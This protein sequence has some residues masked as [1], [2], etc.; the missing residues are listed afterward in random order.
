MG[1]FNRLSDAVAALTQKLVILLISVTML[2]LVFQVFCRYIL[3]RAPSWTDELALFCFSWMVFLAGS[4]GVKEGFHVSLDLLKSFLPS[5]VARIFDYSINILILIFGVFFAVSGFQY[6]AGTMGRVSAAVRYPLVWLNSSA[7]LAG[8]F[9]VIHTFPR[10]HPA[11]CWA[12]K[13]GVKSAKET[14]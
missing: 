1:H 10:L 4:L 9:I 3:A 12:E 7:P 5:Q 6:V 14:K 2:S 8:V 13:A 11:I